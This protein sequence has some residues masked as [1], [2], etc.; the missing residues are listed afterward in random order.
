MG[1]RSDVQRAK[2]WLRENGHVRGTTY[3]VDVPSLAREFEAAA[4]DEIDE[5]DRHHDAITA[6]HRALGGDG[7]WVLR[8]PAVAP[9]DSGNL[10]LD[11]PELAAQVRSELDD[12]KRRIEELEEAHAYAVV[13]CRSLAEHGVSIVAG[14][15]EANR[16]HWVNDPGFITRLS[17]TWRVMGNALAD[18][19]DKRVPSDWMDNVTRVD[20]ERI[21]TLEKSVT[22]L[23]DRLFSA[24][25]FVAHVV[26]ELEEGIPHEDAVDFVCR[27]HEVIRAT[28][29]LDPTDRGKP[30]WEAEAE[31]RRTALVQRVRS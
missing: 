16:S 31:S 14:S 7:D 6:A 5:R 19:I 2:D 3:E 10:D 23:R 13:A 26:E 18:M 29:A 8:I 30:G 17:E 20:S 15:E 11:L 21:A 4:G 12:A 25:A 27:S 1:A 24:L 9:P 22:V 28:D